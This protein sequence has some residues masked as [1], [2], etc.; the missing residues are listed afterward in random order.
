MC[1]EDLEL[2]DTFP[3]K[4]LFAEDV[5]IIARCL[6]GLVDVGSSG[7]RISRASSSGCLGYPVGRG[8][9]LLFR[10]IESYYGVPG[11]SSDCAYR[12][13]SCRNSCDSRDSIVI[14]TGGEASW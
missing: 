7:G 14:D 6:G 2:F 12:E 11:W 13:P 10:C 9:T 1:A 8:L 3:G 4:C 5:E